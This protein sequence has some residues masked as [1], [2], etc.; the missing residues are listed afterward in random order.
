MNPFDKIGEQRVSRSAFNLSYEKKYTCDMA[1]II[2]I[3]ADSCIPGDIWELGNSS[4]VRFQPLVAPV[5]H[6]IQLKT[7]YFFVPNR[8]I[9]P[10]WEEFITRGVTGDVV[11]VLPLMRPDDQTIPADMIAEGTL[12]DYFGFP[13]GIN[14]PDD[15]LP[16][17]YPRRSYYQIWND[18][19][20]DQNLQT[21]IDITAIDNFTIK[22]I[23]WQKDY[24][25][26]SLPFL[27]RGTPP[28]LPVF[29][30]GS[31]DFAIPYGNIAG[32]NINSLNW[33]AMSVSG[34]DSYLGS[35]TGVPTAT[36]GDVTANNRVATIDDFNT[37][38]EDNNTIDGSTFTSADISDIRLAWQL[39]VWMERNARAGARYTEHLQAHFGVS[40]RDERLQRAEFL[41]G[42][43]SDVII[44]E[45]LQTSRSDVGENPQGNL[46]GH[47][48]AVQST[49]IGKYR[50][51]EHGTI[52]GFCVV[53]PKPAYQDGINRQWLY[54]TTFD[55]YSPEFANLSEQ[56]IYNGELIMKDKSVDTDGSYAKGVFGYTGIFNEHRYKPNLVCGEMRSTY[57][58]W[59]LGRQFNPAAPPVLDATFIECIPRKDI[60][61]APSEPGLIISFGNHLNVLRPMPIIAEPM[62]LGGH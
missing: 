61:A 1:Q 26:S 62:D 13:T 14:P 34:G 59:H 8:I 5:L 41:G 23:A 29:G 22:N 4:I 15:G 31:A 33:L 40:P 36:T 17:D 32:S 57:D 49:G 47:G 56:A 20:R 27:L 9:D 19:F 38:L 11:K 10:D 28:A 44:S 53:V 45:V 30:S 42:S 18:Y 39:Q 25:T 51:E 54:R 16:L 37:L 52:M 6:Q 50:V 2:P 35:M 7:Y 21:E 43:T 60:F 12:W 48:I 24:F 3:L 58:Y 55:F 46:A